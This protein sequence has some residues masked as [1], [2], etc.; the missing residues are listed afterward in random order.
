MVPFAPV[1]EITWECRQ[2]GQTKTSVVRCDRV[3][4]DTTNDHMHAEV[5]LQ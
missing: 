4:V 2:P 3:T 1:P 5:E